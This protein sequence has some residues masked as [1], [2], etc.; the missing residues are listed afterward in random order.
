MASEAY[1]QYLI[2][3][4]EIQIDGGVDGLFFDEVGGSYQGATFNGNEGFDDADVAD[5][6]GFLCAKYSDL[7]PAQWQSH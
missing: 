6:G 3:I 4:G 2:G 1:R 5:F 7:I